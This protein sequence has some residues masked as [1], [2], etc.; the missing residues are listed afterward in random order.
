MTELILT[1]D[2]ELH[3]LPTKPSISKPSHSAMKRSGQFEL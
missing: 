3:H 1:M 2:P